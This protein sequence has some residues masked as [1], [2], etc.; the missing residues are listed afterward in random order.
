MTKITKR[1]YL[2]KQPEAGDRI[3]ITREN[4]FGGFRVGLEMTLVDVRS[5]N[6]KVVCARSSML[7]GIQHVHV[8]EMA[9]FKDIIRT[10]TGVDVV[11]KKFLG[12]TYYRKEIERY[13]EDDAE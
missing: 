11:T 2:D 9:I 12:I 7:H 3:V 10:R 6:G 1:I 13:K 5:H 4:Q 8:N